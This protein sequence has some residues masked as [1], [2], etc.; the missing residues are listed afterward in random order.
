M[1]TVG[2]RFRGGRARIELVGGAS[3]VLEGLKP[4]TV[5]IDLNLSGTP[6]EEQGRLMDLLRD[7]K[8]E[9]DLNLEEASPEHFIPLPEGAPGRSRYIATH[10][11]VDFYH[12][13]P[14]SVALGK[15][16]RG[17]ERDFEDVCQLVKSGF[18]DRG[19]LR[20]YFKE[21]LPLVAARSLRDPARFAHNFERLE[22]MW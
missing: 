6:P 7:L 4:V 2:R 13:D 14:Y 10:G 17:E 21:I 22:A 20:E 16:E 9:L 18:V 19:K 12:F 5:D 8:T 15:I 3:L 1:E 11:R